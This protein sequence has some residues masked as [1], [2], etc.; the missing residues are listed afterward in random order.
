VFH[1]KHPPPDPPGSSFD[2]FLDE[3]VEELKDRNLYRSPALVRSAQGPT[4]RIHTFRADAQRG[5]AQ[6]RDEVREVI[7]LASN[8][9]LGLASHPRLL[10]AVSGSLEELGL[11]SSAS[12]LISGTHGAHR[13]AERQLAAWVGYEDALLF[14]SGYAANVGTLAALGERGGVFFS[15][16]LNHAS[17][18]DGCRLS[19]ART[20]V[21]PHLY[22]GRFDGRL[23]GRLD[24]EALE[25]SLAAHR[26]EGEPAVVITEAVFSMDGDLAPLRD[27]REVCDRWDAA[28]MVDEAHSLG[29]LGE[30]GR[31]LCHL[32]GV[33]A[34]LL[35]GTLGKSFGLS[36]A[37]VAG[38]ARL[39]ELLLH[40]ARSFVFSTA[41]PAVLSR[42][43]PVAIELVTEADSARATL[44]SY[45][46]TLRGTAEELGLR[47]SAEHGAEHSAEH[48]ARPRSSIL[49]VVVGAEERALSFSRALL[50]RGVFAQ[51]IRPPTVPEGTSRLR[52][53]PMAT[54]T[55][56]QIEA[57]RRALVEAYRS[58]SPSPSTR[59]PS[60]PTHPTGRGRASK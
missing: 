41:P 17:L 44:A 19:R 26:H 34:D 2:R 4:L 35:V 46:A 7:N 51:A 39:R 23:D 40:R 32:D 33:R 22:S 3:K 18:I 42:A 12:R 50:D 16:R 55:P 24:P 36:G 8:N 58:L 60:P 11:G 20:H 57:S 31:G 45:T 21:L 54:H 49:P 9:Y 15:D 5:D 56:A 29:V 13:E 38:S 52:I 37:F 25:R 53:T 30:G 27:L 6:G 43:I 10:E 48:S 47:S 28:L 14:S 1:V 59:S